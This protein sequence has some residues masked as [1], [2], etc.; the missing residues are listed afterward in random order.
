VKQ[1]QLG[2]KKKC[3]FLG[4]GYKVVSAL[5]SIFF[6]PVSC[7]DD[8]VSCKFFFAVHFH[9]GCFQTVTSDKHRP[10]MRAEPVMLSFTILCNDNALNEM[11]LDK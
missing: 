9:L 7:L 8:V 2:L 3:S 4:P 1:S 5:T 6:S 10:A 11:K